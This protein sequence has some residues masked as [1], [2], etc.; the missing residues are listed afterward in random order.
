M[1]KFIF[2][3]DNYDLYSIKLKI[4]EKLSTFLKNPKLFKKISIEIWI[5]YSNIKYDYE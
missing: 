5:N 3:S 1:V 4:L 2:L